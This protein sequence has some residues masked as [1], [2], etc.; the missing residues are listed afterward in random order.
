MWG[1]LLSQ[2]IIPRFLG[3][4]SRTLEILSTQRVKTQIIASLFNDLWGAD[5]KENGPPPQLPRRT[6]P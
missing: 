4:C 5:G 2:P 6:A 3:L 1:M